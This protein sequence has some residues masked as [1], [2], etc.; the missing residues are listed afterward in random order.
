[1]I[2]NLRTILLLV[3]VAA[4][5][6]AAPPV[7]AQDSLRIIATVN[8]EAI[9]A[10]DLASRMRMIIVS[11]NLED[12][13][14]VRRR[15]A[16]QVLRS[17]IDE[18]LR[19]QETD[20]LDIAVPA[21]RIEDRIDQIAADNNL[22]RAEFEAMLE[23][24]GIK[25]EWIKSQIETEI[26]WVSLIQQKFRP[27]VFVSQEDI[28]EVLRRIQQNQGRPEYLVAEIFLG[29]DDPSE[30]GETEESATR[31]LEELR[32]GASFASVARQFSQA[33]SASGGGNLGW[34]RPGDLAPELDQALDSLQV[35]EVAGPIR[36]QGG[37][38]LILLRDR[39]ETATLAAAGGSVTLKQVLFPLKSGA[40][41]QEVD[42]ADTDA[43]AVVDKVTSC[44]DI[45]EISGDLGDGAVSSLEN[46]SVDDLPGTIQTIA[47]TQ[48]V[49]LP[50]DP[51]HVKEG[52]A[53]FVVCARDLERGDAPSPQ[54]I[55][56]QIVRERLDLLARG[57]IRDLRRSATLD[58]R[59]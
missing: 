53:V 14:E 52:L 17:L 59:G 49:G 18:K 37:F 29:I 24:S 1:M 8:D 12:T 20:R 31:L 25:I 38:H 33:A 39:R 55:A 13:D 58:I 30:T 9:T 34:V 3:L 43:R 2:S 44:D 48:P 32:G 15:M 47:V 27:T 56:D 10:F 23:R 22:S 21:A 41:P 57:Y 35:G 28:G 4:A 36:G 42:D 6:F 51:I 26:A 11:S 16:P 7:A 46:A 45:A 40:T 19:R 5:S 54:Q 50:S